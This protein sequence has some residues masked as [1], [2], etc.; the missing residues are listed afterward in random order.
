MASIVAK[1]G[2]AAVASAA[3]G[4]SKISKISGESIYKWRLKAKWLS[5]IWREMANESAA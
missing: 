1:A 3:Y 4:S 2:L 5:S